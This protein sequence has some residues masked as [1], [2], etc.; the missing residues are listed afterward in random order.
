MVTGLRAFSGDLADILMATQD[1]E[2]L[3]VPPGRV[4]LDLARV[5]GRATARDVADRV[6][7]AAEL[8]RLLAP[9][10]EASTSPAGVARR[11]AEAG[12]LRT[13]VVAP[14]SGDEGRLH[15]AV[16]VHEELLR[17]LVR[18]PRMRVLARQAGA[19]VPGAAVVELYAGEL[20][21]ATIRRG[22]ARTTLHLPLDIAS[23]GLAADAIASAVAEAVGSTGAGAADPAA[24]ALELLLRARMLAQ[25]SL[26]GAS[27]AIGMVERAHA[28]CPDD[29]RIAATLAMLSVRVVVVTEAQV[30]FERARSLVHAALAAAPQLADSHVAAGHLELH[31]GEAGPAAAHFRTAI[32]CSPYVAEAHEGLGRMLLEAG[33]LDVA[34]ARLEDALA[35]APDLNVVRWEIAR[36]HALEQDWASCDAMI[37]ELVTYSDRIFGRMR[38]AWWR[39]DEGAMDATYNEVKRGGGPQPPMMD[40]LYAIAVQRRW[41]E[42]RDRML[43][44]VNGSTSPS[45][46][47]RAFL[48]QLGAEA[49][50]YSGDLRTCS[51][52][53]DQAVSWGLFDLHWFDRCPLI[54]A[55][56]GT[57]QSAVA[58]LRVKQRAEAILDAL[59]GDNQ[60]LSDTIVG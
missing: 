42:W 19:G 22:D 30:N 11:P 9:W 50:G 34:M 23:V 60:A 44:F 46:R 49:A 40:M 20:L 16:G 25:R 1:V 12:D 10:T 38:L 31:T 51:M 26:A 18:R 13:V 58:R 6:A 2:R 57:A 21:S 4:P 59:Y 24:Q 48:A 33:F 5:I 47:R 53:I 56:R 36:A 29:P 43:G 52:L 54:E 37:A 17:R 14:P 35:I 27:Q 3:G 8:G 28:L 55:V 32:A 7:S 39:G 41:P 15:L 45:R